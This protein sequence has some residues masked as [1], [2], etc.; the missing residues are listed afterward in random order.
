MRFPQQRSSQ[1]NQQ[2]AP[3]KSNFVAPFPGPPPFPPAPKFATLPAA[4][5]P[6]AS[7]PCELPTPDP[8]QYSA[9][10]SPLSAFLSPRPEGLKL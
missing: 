5:A 4:V 8:C 6:E 2:E 9:D 10:S 7:W 3:V 1:P